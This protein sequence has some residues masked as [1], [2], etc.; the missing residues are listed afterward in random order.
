M[1]KLMSAV[2]IAL[3]ATSGAMACTKDGKDGIF[4]ENNLWIPVGQKTAFGANEQ[5]FVAAIE[6]AQKFYASVFEAQGRTLKIFNHW[7]DGTVNAYAKRNGRV[8]EVHMFGG[9]ARH[10]L[11][12]KDAFMLVICHELG[13]HLGGFP[14]SSDWATN[15]GGADYFATLKCAREMWKDEANMNFRTFLEVPEI[16]RTSCQKGF[17][18]PEEIGLCARASMAGKAL[19]DTLSDLGK[20]PA[21]DFSTPD[22]SVVS[23]TNNEHPK[24]QCRTDTY[25]AG[26][27]CPVAKDVPQSDT[28]AA[29]GTCEQ[30]KGDTFG[31]RPL[32]WYKPGE[33]GGGGGGGG[34]GGTT[35]PS[36]GV[37]RR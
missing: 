12:T 25:F 4:P 1:K 35:W 11:V 19:G 23:R 22:T 2:L 7:E 10:N 29:P 5:E 3:F 26:A 34:G 15:E 36:G 17:S 6:K 27:V 21:T 18:K 14:K 32:C 8:S 30:T 31:V 33:Q 24:A 20:G 16:V 13:H 28:E 37:R 9:L